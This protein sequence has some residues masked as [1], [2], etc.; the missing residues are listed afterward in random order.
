MTPRTIRLEDVDDVYP[1][2]GL[3][4]I[5]DFNETPGLLDDLIDGDLTDS[6]N[7]LDQDD[8]ADELRVLK[9]EVVRLGRGLRHSRREF[10]STLH[11][12]LLADGLTLGQIAGRLH[13]D[14][15]DVDSELIELQR[16]GLIVR[17]DSGAAMARYSI[18]GLSEL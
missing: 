15:R 8:L 14:P 12:L 9:S 11:V 10:A 7:D 13:R 4:S 2:Y 5:D 18:V 16:V 3:P 6:R 1:G 17:T